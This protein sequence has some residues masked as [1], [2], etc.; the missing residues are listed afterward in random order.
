MVTFLTELDGDDQFLFLDELFLHPFSLKLL[1]FHSFRYH[2]NFLPQMPS[3][4]L[5]SNP[6]LSM[7]S[8]LNMFCN[9]HQFAPQAS[10]SSIINPL[11]L[12]ALYQARL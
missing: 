5:A 4:K 6:T 7:R 10:P 3:V 1:P 11:F 8:L 12:E 2:F 9:Q